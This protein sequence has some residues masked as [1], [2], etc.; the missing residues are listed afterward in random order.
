MQEKFI[1]GGWSE[2][3]GH[4]DKQTKDNV[5]SN[6]GWSPFQ[7]IYKTV[8]THLAGQFSFY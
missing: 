4:T 3:D 8:L 7:T 2:R 5:V 1:K 6:K